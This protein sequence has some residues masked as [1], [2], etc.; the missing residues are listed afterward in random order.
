MEREE[1]LGPILS[2]QEGGLAAQG[3]GR[4]FPAFTSFNW[5]VCPFPPEW[6]AHQGSGGGG[7]VSGCKL[8]ES[9][10]CF[11]LGFFMAGPALGRGPGKS[12]KL[13]F[14]SWL[15]L[16]ELDWANDLTFGASDHS[17]VK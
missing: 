17:S 6:T 12:R 5:L 7:F 15:C 14:S 13:R 8:F 9:A 11:V 4:A 1:E 10:F 3:P 16:A 2:R